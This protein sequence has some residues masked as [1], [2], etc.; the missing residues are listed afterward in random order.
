MKLTLDLSFVGKQQGIIITDG[1][2][3]RSFSQ[4]SIAAGKSSSHR[5]AARRLCHSTIKPKETESESNQTWRTRPVHA[6][7]RQRICC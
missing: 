7:F 4:R 5:Q 2:Q 1:D 6:G 3:P